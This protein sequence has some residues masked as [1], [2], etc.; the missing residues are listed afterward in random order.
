MKA[1]ST[2][3]EKK[4]RNSSS[5]WTVFLIH[6]QVAA[7]FLSSFLR[8]RSLYSAGRCCISSRVI[9]KLICHRDSQQPIHQRKLAWSIHISINASSWT[10]F[11]IIIYWSGGGVDLLSGRF[12]REG[13]WCSC[14]L[15]LL[16]HF[17]WKSYMAQCLFL[18]LL[19]CMGI[20]RRN[21]PRSS[22]A[23]LCFV[24]S[25][26]RYIIGSSRWSLIRWWYSITFL[27]C[28]RFSSVWRN[29]TP[30]ILERAAAAA[31]AHAQYFSPLNWM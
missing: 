13:V 30:P 16:I 9:I 8:G 21:T 18:L 6:Q 23:H 3:R 15:F 31:A 17:V 11:K 12:M 24:Y 27:W 14:P 22:N 4:Y 20:C 28:L 7:H 2:R 10:C 26:A 19:C 29:L 25:S 5:C 1:S